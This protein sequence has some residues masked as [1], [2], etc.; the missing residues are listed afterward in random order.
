[1]QGPVDWGT[2]LWLVGVVVAV[3]IAAGGAGGFTIWRI[4]TILAEQRH[5]LRG[6]FAEMMAQA[7]AET[8]ALEKDLAQIRV[9]LAE[10]Y[11]SKTGVAAGFDR[12]VEQ[13]R[14]LRD[15]VKEGLGGLRRDMRE[16]VK[17]LNDRMTGID[18]RA[19]SPGMG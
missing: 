6:E 17:A 5:T 8:A 11:A 12:V 2:L 7:Q 14:E 9:N 18:T 4:A 13:L 10:N 15:E 16:D 1:M 3:A 19:R